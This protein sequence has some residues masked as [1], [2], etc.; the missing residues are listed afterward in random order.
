MNGDKILTA[1]KV[2]VLMAIGVTMLIYN[3]FIYL[4]IPG[5]SLIHWILLL[6]PFLPLLIAVSL[7]TI[8]KKK[9]K[10]NGKTNN[11]HHS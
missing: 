2:S 1:L 8:D 7:I 9:R 6:T 10:I 11:I 4:I 3:A 5:F